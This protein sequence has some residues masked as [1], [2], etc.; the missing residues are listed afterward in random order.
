MLA[1]D[2]VLKL[3]DT[4]AF[5]GMGDSSCDSN[6]ILTD[7]CRSFK[8]GLESVFSG[9]Q[10]TPCDGTRMKYL[11]GN[12]AGP[13]PTSYTCLKFPDSSEIFSYIFSKTPSKANTIHPSG[14]YIGYLYID[15]NGPKKPN[16]VGRD[17]FE[18]YIGNNGVV[19]PSGSQAYSEIMTND[20]N[21]YYWRTTIS[22]S[23]KCTTDS[24]GF[25]C[26][27]RVLEEGKMDY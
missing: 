21:R 6:T 14:G 27:G 5:S 1:H 19:Y 16:T 9:I 24:Y 12:N 3:S 23:Y 15:V 25:G 11:N 8:E 17:I 10:F 4:T 7:Y 22:N 2:E 26:A 20:P 13:K 18:L